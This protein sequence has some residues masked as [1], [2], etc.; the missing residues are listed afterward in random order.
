M[1]KNERMVIKKEIV[2][3]EEEI[4]AELSTQ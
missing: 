4:T 2:V 1:I 3:K